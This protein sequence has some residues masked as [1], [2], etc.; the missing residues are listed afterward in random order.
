MVVNIEIM[1]SIEI[2]GGPV[3]K[4]PALAMQM[5]QVQLLVRS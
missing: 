3:V 1:L 4:T 5:K 2:S